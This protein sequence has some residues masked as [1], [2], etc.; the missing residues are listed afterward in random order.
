[1]VRIG[2]SV[3][4]L[5]HLAAVFLAPMS[6]R[7]S[8]QLV[9]DIAQQPPMQ[10]YLD[11]LYINHGYFFFAPEPGDGHLIYFDVFDAQGNP[12]KQGKF[13]DWDLHWPRLWYHRYFMLAEQV[14]GWVPDEQWQK[15]SLEA[16]ARQL[17]REFG[18][19]TVRVRWIAHKIPHPHNQPRPPK[20]DEPASYSVRMEVVQRR[21]DLGP[22][23]QGE[24]QAGDEPEVANRW[25]GVPR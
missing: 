6:V 21:S 22:E 19:E 25:I 3:L 12:I 23:E 13:P 14:G 20:L 17:L 11:L 16:Y 10:W 24:K 7:P 1:L 2:I 4:L 15:K 18:G 8:S 9:I 5:W